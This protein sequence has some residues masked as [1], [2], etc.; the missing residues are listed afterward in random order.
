MLRALVTILLALLMAP[1]AHAVTVGADLST[2]KDD[3]D[4]VPSCFGSGDQKACTLLAL[5]SSGA[6]L[7]VPHDGIITSWA[8][9]DAKGT[10]GLR[11]IEGAAGARR[12]VGTA[13]NVTVPGVGLQSFP[14][15]IPVKTGQ[16]IGVEIS[17]DGGIPIRYNQEGTTGERYD[18]PLGATP[19]AV[20][21]S[22]VDSQYDI[23]YAYTVETDL[24][25]DGLADDTRDPDHGGKPGSTGCATNGVVFT[26]Q[27]GVILKNGSTYTAC[28][29]GV[30]T[31]LGT[32]SKK[33]KL[34]L[35]R[36]TD[37]RSMSRSS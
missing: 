1:A 16:R 15:T 32:T 36:I 28:R 29:F 17:A 6:D 5:T 11:I 10:L 26:A 4:Q 30:V 13:P 20:D 31:P 34:R 21:P 2:G 14:A 8:V 33:V 27:G 25:G 35:F 37:A 7:A 22:A 12:V 24:D 23:L 3:P 9:R 18:P 19:Q